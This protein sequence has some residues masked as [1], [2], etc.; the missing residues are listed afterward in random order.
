[1]SVWRWY[2]LSRSDKF[3]RTTLALRKNI[4]RLR[5]EACNGEPNLEADPL[6][7]YQH[8]RAVEVIAQI[9]G[10]LARRRAQ[11]TPHG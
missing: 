9:D 3:L 4:E 6:D 2:G 10:E 7:Y 11:E 5:I 1:M 8:R